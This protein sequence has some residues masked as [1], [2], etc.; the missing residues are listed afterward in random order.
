MK[1]VAVLLVVVAALVVRQGIAHHWRLT[2]NSGLQDCRT[3][4]ILDDGC[5]MLGDCLKCVPACAPGTEPS[6]LARVGCQ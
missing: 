4:T 3:H 5:S 6:P 2:A 1:W